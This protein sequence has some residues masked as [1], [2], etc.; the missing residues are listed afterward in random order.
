VS[1]GLSSTGSSLG[2]D[3]AWTVTEKTS[4]TCIFIQQFTND[5]Y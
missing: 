2:G 1:L 5:K 3:I 4:S